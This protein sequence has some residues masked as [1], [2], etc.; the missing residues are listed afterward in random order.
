M[1]DHT[2]CIWLISKAS[3]NLAPAYFLCLFSLYF[4]PLLLVLW[5]KWKD[6]N[7]KL[8]NLPAFDVLPLFVW[9]AVP[10]LAPQAPSPPF[11]FIPQ[12]GS[13]ALLPLGSCFLVTSASI[14]HLHPMHIFFLAIRNNI[15]LSAS[16]TK[17]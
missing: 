17:L 9:N 2:S 6:L 3:Y 7:L 16:L 13:Q 4:L 12:S 15:Y 10:T 5:S 1:F 14:S 11:L 8:P